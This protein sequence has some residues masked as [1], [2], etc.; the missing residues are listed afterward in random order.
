MAGANDQIDT[1]AE[2][3][4]G[5]RFFA[6]VTK[7]QHTRISDKRPRTKGYTGPLYQEAYNSE[8]IDRA[9]KSHVQFWL[10]R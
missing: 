4:F 3:P 9:G 6:G 2:P 8:D 10:S 7:M 5:D 1:A